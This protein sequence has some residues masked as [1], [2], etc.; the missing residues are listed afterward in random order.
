MV[1]FFML[2][3]SWCVAPPR[4]AVDDP[5]QLRTIAKRYGML[6]GRAHA[7]ALT[8]DRVLG[9][10]VIAPLI[11]GRE[12]ELADEIAAFATADAAQIISDHASMRDKDLAALLDLGGAR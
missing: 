8:A 1:T 2:R 12:T 6:L 7:Q 3:P 4:V 9:V 11:A 5:V 10:T